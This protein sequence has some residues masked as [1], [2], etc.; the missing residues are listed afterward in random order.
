MRNILDKN[1][2]G[3]Q[4]NIRVGF[5]VAPNPLKRAKNKYLK[6]L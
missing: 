3:I 5:T 2:E 4:E 1:R 6:S